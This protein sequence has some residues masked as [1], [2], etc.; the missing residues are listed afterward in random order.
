MRVSKAI[1][2]GLHEIRFF[3]HS[4]C[5]C[6]VCAPLFG[7]DASLSDEEDEEICGG[8][9]RLSTREAVSD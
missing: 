6:H 3:D 7:G 2:K 4:F 8:G 5:R 1:A 9:I